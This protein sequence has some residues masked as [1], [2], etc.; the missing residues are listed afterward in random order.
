MH[1]PLLLLPGMMCD[2]RLFTHQIARLSQDRCVVIGPVTQGE[3]VAEM[4]RFILQAAPPR[5]ALA[6]HGLGGMVAMEIL[7]LA[8][9]QV[10]R[11][12]LIDTSPL[13]ELPTVAAEREPQIM[14]ARLGRLEQ[15]LQDE[16]KPDYLSPQIDRSRVLAQYRRMGMDLGPDIFIRQTRAMQR[17]PDQQKTLRLAKLPAFAIC[18]EHDALCPV[19]RHEIMAGLMPHGEIRTIA[20]AGH[21]APLEQP[22]ALTAALGEWLKAPLTLH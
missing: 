12:A 7:K 1:E 22:V 21:L 4:A 6:G 11:L 18:G 2:A 16:M 5:F 10:T 9:E 15:A 8:P 19:H 13:A 3:S 20:N 14:A 17:R